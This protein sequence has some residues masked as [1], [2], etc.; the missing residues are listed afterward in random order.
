MDYDCKILLGRITKIHGNDG[1][2]SVKLEQEFIGN[3]PEMES[4]FLETE[5]KPVPFF[6][7][8]YE[9]NGGDTVRFQFQGYRSYDKLAEFS[10]CRIFLTSV[11]DSY[12]KDD[13]SEDLTGF[14]VYSSLNK[15]TGTVTETIINPGQIL[16]LIS[17]PGG[18]EMLIPFHEDL[19]VSIDRKKKKIIMNLPEGLEEINI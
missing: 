18:K 14:T 6:I 19:I 11:P 4:V 5:G 8:S 15:V 13:S 2:V 17:N 10:G 9:Y 16:L 3:L 7:Y 12:E 1:S